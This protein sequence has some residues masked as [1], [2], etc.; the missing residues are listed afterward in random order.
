MNY[1]KIPY[2]DLLS[3]ADATQAPGPIGYIFHIAH[4][5]STLLARGLDLKDQNLVL[6]EPYTLRQLGVDAAHGA[7]GDFERK[8]RLTRTLL[9]RRYNQAGPV[10]VKANVPANFLIPALMGPQADQ[11]AIFLHY[12]LEDYLLA[13]LRSPMHRNWVQHVSNEL[14]P[15]IEALTGARAASESEPIAAARLWLT[16]ML[17]FEAALAAY[18]KARSLNAEALFET[19]KAVLAAAFELF[20]QPQSDGTIEAIVASELFSR[21]SKDP[22]HQFDNSQRIGRRE[23]LKVELASELEIGRLWVA[24]RAE[25]LPERLARPLFGDGASLLANLP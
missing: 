14:A 11:A 20:G 13:I 5:G 6:R 9:A 10:I 8:V 21:Y 19:P 1:R 22:R 17:Q 18:P 15:G 24:A 25:R 12:G 3:Q 16:Q 7:G 4:C 23:K 2:A